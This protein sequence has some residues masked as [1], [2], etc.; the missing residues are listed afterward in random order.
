MQDARIFQATLAHLGRLM[1]P[2]RHTP[3][4]LSVL[5]LG[6]VLVAWP[7]M[8]RPN[9]EPISRDAPAVAPASE[10]PSLPWEPLEILGTRVSTGTRASLSLVTSDSYSGARIGVPVLVVHGSQA[11]RTTCLTGGIHGDELNGIEIVR[12]VMRRIDPQTLAGSVIGIPVVNLHGFRRGERDLPDRR[13]LNRHF[14]GRKKGSAASRVAFRVFEFLSQHCHEGIDFHTGSSRRS[15][16]PQVRADVGD[17]EVLELALRVLP[18]I[19]VHSPGTGG[20]LRRALTEAGVPT[21]TYEAG[22]ALRFQLDV[23]RGRRAR[24]RRRDP[25]QSFAIHLASRARQGPRSVRAVAMGPSRPRWDPD[26]R[27]RAR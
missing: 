10:I 11:G 15:N 17:P 7:F 4:I 3:G 18:P 20:M 23:D 19:I 25:E 2:P 12:R 26:E 21:I 1:C 22:E 14:P 9:L 6:V 16:F 24:R 8:A 13:D 27:G 5:A